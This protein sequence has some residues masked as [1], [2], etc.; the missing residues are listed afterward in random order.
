M[1][2]VRE[3]KLHEKAFFLIGVGPLPSA[4]T[5]RWMKNNVPGVHIPEPVLER[6]E[7]AKD[8]KAEGKQLC[9]DLIQE[10]SEIEG[11]AGI[12]VMGLSPGGVRERDH[13]R[14]RRHE[15]PQ[16]AACAAARRTNTGARRQLTRRISTL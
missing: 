9:I 16:A 15:E 10:I 12:H 5:G 7:K 3:N 1:E 11:V 6:I 13:P 4:K 14:L 8:Q 2:K